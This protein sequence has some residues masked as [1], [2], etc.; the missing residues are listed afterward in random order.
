MREIV[1]E[2]ALWVI[3]MTILGTLVLI[4]IDGLKN[5]VKW[6]SKGINDFFRK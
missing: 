1:R 3:N 5:W 4:L 6:I 2:I